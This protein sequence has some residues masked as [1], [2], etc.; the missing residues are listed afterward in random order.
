MKRKIIYICALI[1]GLMACKKE[2]RYYKAYLDNA[3]RYYPGALDSLALYPGNGRAQVH[4]RLST[5]PK[6]KKLRLV[7]TNDLNALR[8]TLFYTIAA[9]EIGHDKNVMLD[10]LKETRYTVSA[11]GFSAEGDSS[12]AITATTSVEGQRY[13]TTV[14][15]LNR[16]FS[17]FTTSPAGRKQAIFFVET[18]GSGFTPLQ[19]TRIYFN[20]SGNARDSVFLGPLD[21]AVEFPADILPKGSISFVSYYKKTMFSLD[22][23]QTNEKIVNY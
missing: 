6:I 9:S 2:D 13:G 3:E 5:D 19:G 1:V 7:V 14:L 17:N 21:F 16:V 11:R 23:F 8:D 12:K 4:M 18:V 10:K 22:N 15:S 20:R